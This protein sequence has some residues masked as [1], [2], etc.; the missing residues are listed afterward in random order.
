MRSSRAW[1]RVT[2]RMVASGSTVCPSV[3]LHSRQTARKNNS[4]PEGSAD[5]SAIDVA[6]LQSQ[7]W[8]RKKAAALSVARLAEDGADPLRPHALALLHALL[9]EASAQSPLSSRKHSACRVH[10][11]SVSL[12]LR[13]CTVS[14]YPTP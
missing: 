14:T 3:P 8:G 12:K 7:Q 2:E 1:R 5:L 13:I 11:G 10:V 9:A 4:A 6:G